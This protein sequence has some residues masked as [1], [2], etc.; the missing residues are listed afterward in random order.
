MSNRLVVGWLLAAGRRKVRV[1]VHTLLSL[2]GHSALG[3]VG[4]A[5][6]GCA[7]SSE[8]GRRQMMGHCGT[9]RAR[10]LSKDSQVPTYVGCVGTCRYALII[11][12]FSR[13]NQRIDLVAC[14]SW[15][16]CAITGFS[17][18]NSPRPLQSRSGSFPRTACVHCREF[19]HPP[20]SGAPH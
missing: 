14:F 5:E 7:A 1:R 4:R 19:Q 20:A 6:R 16:T 10:T 2:C 17:G 11:T 13:Q 18:S 9:C 3:R 15:A 12:T 8:R